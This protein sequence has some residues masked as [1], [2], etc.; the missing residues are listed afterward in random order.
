MQPN[1]FSQLIAAAREGSS[2]ALGELLE[3][4]R[5]SLIRFARRELSLSLADKCGGS[6]LVQDTFIESQLKFSDF[7]GSSS[8]EFLGWMLN[9]LR[10]NIV[11][12][13]RFYMCERR[14]VSRETREMRGGPVRDVAGPQ[15]PPV[16]LASDNERAETI[17]RAVNSLQETSRQVVLLRFRDGLSFEQIADRLG[18]VSG[19]AARKY[20]SRAL[21]K[22]GAIVSRD[23]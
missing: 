15:K 4:Y 21:R 16:D 17:R 13:H 23:A 7:R 12:A 14:R 19:E 10:H 11:D 20:S 22:L 3:S 1:Q 2:V 6:D 18:F 8:G 5:S 9:I